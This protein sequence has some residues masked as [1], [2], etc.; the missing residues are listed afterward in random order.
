LAVAAIA[1]EIA[2]PPTIRLAARPTVQERDP[3][4]RMRDL[5]PHQVLAL[6][7]RTPGRIVIDRCRTKIIEQPDDEA[8]A[9]NSKREQYD[10]VHA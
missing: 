4:V 8:N 1:D 2:G 9:T 5:D 3:R 7:P 10:Q 6:T